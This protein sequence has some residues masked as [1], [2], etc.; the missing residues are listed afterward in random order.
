MRSNWN[1]VIQLPPVCAEKTRAAAWYM[2]PLIMESLWNG[3]LWRFRSSRQKYDLLQL[4]R[5][6]PVAFQPTA[7]RRFL[8]AW[9]GE[10]RQ[11]SD[12]GKNKMKSLVRRAVVLFRNKRLEWSFNG[13][14]HPPTQQMRE[15]DSQVKVTP[16]VRNLSRWNPSG[17]LFARVA[18]GGWWMVHHFPAPLHYWWQSSGKMGLIEACR[19][20]RSFCSLS[21]Q[22]DKIR[23]NFIDP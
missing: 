22:L 15:V 11:R 18:E 4:P 7:L 2:V 19:H 12:G 10:K 16:H 9:E 14:F 1:A 5:P 6:F 21:I 13:A 23:K 3:G 17:W 20:W 8:E